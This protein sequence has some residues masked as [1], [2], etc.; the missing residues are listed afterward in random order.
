MNEN[1]NF[2]VYKSS[3]GSGKT[4]TLV[5]EYLS[6]ALA[7]K[8]PDRYKNILAITFTNKAAEEMKN[9]VT[10]YLK[11]L[12]APKNLSGGE[13]LM[14]SNLKKELNIGEEELKKRAFKML[15]SILHN[16]SDF[17]IT[18]IDKF[19][20][21]IIRSFSFDLQL[22]YNFEVELDSET[23][24]NKAINNLLA[25]TGKDKRLTAFL[26]NYIKQLAQ[27]DES[28]N[29][30]NSLLKV[31]KV[32]MNE[33]AL[34]HL[35]KLQNLQ[36]EDF[37]KIKGKIGL[38]IKKYEDFVRSKTLLG[39]ETIT[40][41]NIT[42]AILKGKTRINI[43]AYFHKKID[44][45]CFEEEATPKYFE[46]IEKEEW[47]G[48]GFEGTIPPEVYTVLKNLFL[49]IETYKKKNVSS[50][51][52][53][54]NIFKNLFQLGLLNE[55]E[56]QVNII[57][58]EQNFIHISEFNKKVAEIV[59]EQPIPFIYERI[60]EK[61]NNYLI[62]EFQD[63]SILQ[64]Q[65]LLPLIENSLAYDNKNLIVGD[66]KQAIY[67]WRGGDVDQFSL[68]PEAPQFKNNTIIQERIQT[69][70]RQFN[71]KNLDSNYRSTKETIEFNNLFFKELLNKL[72]DFFKPYY[73]EFE[74]KVG[75]DKTGGFA[76]IKI[77]EKKD[78]KENTL[79]EI[80]DTINDCTQ[81][82][83][84]LK[85]ISI[86]T[87]KNKDLTLIA[88]FLTHHKIPVIS[89][90]S[91]NLNQSEEVNFLVSLFSSIMNPDNLEGVINVSAYLNKIKPLD[92]FNVF[93]E[94]NNAFKTLKN[95]LKKNYNIKLPG[96]SG[97]SLYEGFEELISA[98]QF[99]KSNPFIQTFLDVVKKQAP[100]LNAS[101]F[102][103]Y[104]SEKR[105][106]LKI[107][108]P[109]NID[110]VTLMTIHKSKGLE[111]PIIIMPF[112]N[113]APNRDAWLWLNTNS[114]ELGIGS[115][116]TKNSQKMLKTDFSEQSEDEKLKIMLDELNVTYVALTRAAEET[117]VT[118][119][120]EKKPNEIK[121]VETF[122]HQVLPQLN[123]R[124][125]NT[126]TYGEKTISER[127][128]PP[129]ESTEVGVKLENSNWRN[130]IKISF[131]APTIW[132]VPV[133]SEESFISDD[134]RRFGNLIHTVFAKLDK[135]QKIEQTIDMMYNEGLIDKPDVS[136]IREIIKSTLSLSPLNKIW[137][138]GKHSIE[139]EIITSEGESYR[140][141]RIIQHN[142]NSYLIDFKT[143]EE[144]SKDKKQI[145][146][147]ATLLSELNIMNIKSYLVY[148][149]KKI[150]REVS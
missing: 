123:E 5:K 131:S 84:A 1:G 38:D 51:I 58:E 106:G 101:E 91:L 102:I 42:P 146:N 48:K 135:E 60:G 40:N 44:S 117:F 105:E 26:V 83:K 37:A 150:S 10:Q 130:K 54:S 149:D 27:D 56:K 133:N 121:G 98:F 109:Q 126:F 142:G 127:K 71:P 111:F 137:K 119:C 89:N 113:T 61:F 86:L 52:L 114:E 82:G 15:Q 32:S 141:D 92:Y 70:K 9:R 112:A 2:L 64:W 13:E 132:D 50:Y 73:A 6:V 34:P 28:W 143:G 93:S 55:L 103:E 90:E 3:A 124:E 99:D 30:Q 8:N 49:E 72:P 69:L 108:S 118:I 4:Y 75:L 74:Q 116:L 97:L 140:P 100:L 65:N 122:F 47:G 12:S 21:K 18:T 25:E 80:L 36:L 57:R 33:D 145:R 148:T 20:L 43:W 22:P 68:L 129:K 7:S 39:K 136:S 138:E 67:R 110:A 95:I 128:S 35:Q 23:L 139:K 59:V 96:I 78:Y 53:K 88:E 107:A 19:I 41:S 94:R 144:K 147:Y 14:F 46:N 87:K 134:P 16:Y 76:Q 104:W 63:T 85:D 17:N 120:E 29:I 81:R 79:S 62:D 45:N 125:K 31:A 24:L 66:A 11:S 115:S 77:L